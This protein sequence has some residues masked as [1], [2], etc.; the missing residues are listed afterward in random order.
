M[1]RAL[2]AVILVAAFFLSGQ[3]VSTNPPTF[4]VTYPNYSYA[5]RAASI[6]DIDFRNVNLIIFDEAG[7]PELAA[8]L[9]KGKFEQ[10]HRSGGHE[11]VRIASVKYFGSPT[12]GDQRA[13]VSIDGVSAGGSSSSYG[14][15]QVFG[16]VDE[17]PF[18]TQQIEY[19]RRGEGT[20]SLFDSQKGILRIEGVHGWEHCC[21]TTL[22]RSA[23][24]EH[25]F[26]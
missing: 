17:H 16:I 26:G 3:S 2:L 20:G 22:E 18:V 24:M 19:N 10:N 4:D 11:W 23:G 25:G 12:N 21:P 7:K 15:L 1:N 14:V 13:L 8:K 6:K 5:R 9:R